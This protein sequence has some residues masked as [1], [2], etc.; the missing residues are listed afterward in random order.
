MYGNFRLILTKIDQTKNETFVDKFPHP[1]VMIKVKAWLH[2][3]EDRSTY[4]RYP[5]SVGTRPDDVCSFS[6]T[7]VYP[8]TKKPVELI[9]DDN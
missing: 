9:A 4:S 7:L 8:R 6:N 3:L 1:H 2:P 5:L